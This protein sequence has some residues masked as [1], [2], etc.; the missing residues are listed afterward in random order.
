MPDKCIFCKIIKGEIPN[1]TVY[2]DDAVLAFLDIAPRAKGHTVVIPKKHA[3]RLAD[4]AE[5]DTTAL[6]PAVKRV[7]AKI[8][9][10]LQ[11]D[12]YNMG[13][14]DGEVGGQVVPH[15]HIH[16]MPRWEGDGG[17]NMHSIIDNPG[18]VSVEELSKLFNK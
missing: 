8:E 9:E 18:D 12:G 1:Y 17:G 14:N 10:V 13:W 6:L 2:E 3:K 7:V 11:P 15:L 5:E 4:L 16:I